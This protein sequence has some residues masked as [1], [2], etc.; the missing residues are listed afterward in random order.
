MV[1]HGLAAPDEHVLIEQGVEMQRPSK[2]LVRAARHDY[3][4]V[5]VRAGGD[6]VEVMRGEIFV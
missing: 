3:R 6:A 5:N 4:I 1:A 2:I